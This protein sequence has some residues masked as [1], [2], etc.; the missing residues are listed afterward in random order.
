[1]VRIAPAARPVEDGFPASTPAPVVSAPQA[2]LRGELTPP[3][4]RRDLTPTPVDADELR[5]EPTVRVRAEAL[6]PLLDQAADVMHGIARLREAA[7]RLP[8]H[9]AAR[10][11]AEIDRLRRT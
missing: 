11:E 2:S 6:D 3:P 7:K 1:D 5:P 9:A 4:R 8:E 10:L